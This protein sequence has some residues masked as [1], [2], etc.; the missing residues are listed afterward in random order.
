ML[1]APPHAAGQVPWGVGGYD[2]LLAL[3]GGLL[4]LALALLDA[5]G[6]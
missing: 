6:S 5:E 4:G 2:W 3:V 1:A